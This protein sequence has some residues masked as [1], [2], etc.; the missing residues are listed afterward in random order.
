M[1]IFVMLSIACKVMEIYALERFR[2]ATKLALHA[3]FQGH[4]FSVIS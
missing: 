2:S 1:K 4:I 3:P